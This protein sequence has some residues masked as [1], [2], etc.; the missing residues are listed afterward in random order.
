MKIINKNPHSEADIS[1]VLSP[2]HWLSRYRD[3][4]VVMTLSLM[5]STSIMAAG[6]TLNLE[7]ADIKTLITAVSE[8]TGKNFII[9]PRVKGKVTVV[10]GKPMES[11]ELYQ[12]FLSILDVH[13]FAAV[14]SGS[15]IRIIPNAMAKQAGAPIASGGDPGKGDEIVTRLI[16]LKHVSAAELVPLL[17]PLIPQQGHLAAHPSSNML[18]VT[19]RAQ[20]VS[21]LIKIIQ[22]IDKVSESEI[23]VIQ[24]QHAAAAEVVRI[25]SQ[26]AGGAS[27]KETVGTRMKMVPD[28]RSNAVLLSG[29]PSERL[30]FRTL[31]SHLDTPYESSG[32][33]QVVYLHYAKAKDLATILQSVSDSTARMSGSKESV[34]QSKAVIQADETTNALVI[35]APPNVMKSLKKVISNLDI[36]RAQVLIEVVIVEVT[37]DKSG[38]LGIQWQTNPYETDGVVGGTALPIK[39]QQTLGNF[40][41]ATTGAITMLP[42]MNLGYVVGGTMR[43]LLT[44]LNSDG[45]AN[46]LSMPTLVTL[47]NKEATITV[48]ENVPFVTGQYTSDS[49]TPDNPFQTIERK[50]VGILLKVK[51]QINE[52]DAILLEL[53]QEVSSVD[54]TTSGS[55]LRTKKRE[56]ETSVLVN[57]GDMLVLGGLMEDT[58]S[59]SVNKVPMLGDIPMVGNLFKSR[60]AN[61]KKTNLMV[62]IKPTILRNAEDGLTQTSRKYHRMRSMQLSL[63]QEEVESMLNEKPRVL[64]ESTEACCEDDQIQ[65]SPEDQIDNRSEN[66]LFWFVPG[67]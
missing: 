63:K 43:M 38:K 1:I 17:R 22:R 21:R 54:A 56:I 32:D 18:V 28:E 15:V 48:G 6:I 50:D 59:Q 55:N 40:K 24:L 64:P 33:V 8:V 29:E 45:N 3:A 7:R 4:V 31:I 20:N 30:R 35:S 51:P 9:D 41:S 62:F 23:E 34:T 13:G 12:V 49:S 27:G 65:K 10:S 53:K 5:F 46:I 61:K 52:G 47:D 2:I 11:D 60:Q 42:G 66:D 37:A 14:S 58:S 57:D 25:V 39:D 16:E 44:A 36:R 19:D 67:R 26:L